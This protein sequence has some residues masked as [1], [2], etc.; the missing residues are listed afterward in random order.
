M[1]ETIII[2]N[3][4]LTRELWQQ[5]LDAHFSSNPTLKMRYLWGVLCI[6]IGALG[7]GGFY[8]SPVIASLLLATGLFAVLSKH[9]LVAKSLRTACRH[10]FFG[11]ELT[12]AISQDELSVRSGTSGYRQ[13]WNNFVG[14][15]KRAPGFLLYHDRSAFF[16]VPEG[17]MSA[18]QARRFKDILDAAGVPDLSGS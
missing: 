18:G 17:V 9:L 1:S 3:Y 8:H 14:Y 2:L 12:V 16:F 15:R 6:M 10:P 7:F 4:R 11:E 5:F 13:P